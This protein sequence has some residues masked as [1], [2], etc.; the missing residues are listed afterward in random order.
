MRISRRPIVTGA[1]L[2]AIGG[3]V[4]F[5]LGERLLYR[6]QDRLNDSIGQPLLKPRRGKLG[7][8][9]IS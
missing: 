5:R 9:R 8:R 1:I 6:V 3:W 2:L 7:L 4:A